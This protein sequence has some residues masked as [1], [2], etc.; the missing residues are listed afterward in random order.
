M[1]FD[2]VNVNV[3]GPVQPTSIYKTKVLKGNQSFASQVTESNTKYVIKHDFDLKGEEVEIPAN[4]VL[5]FDGGS[6]TNGTILFNDTYIV[7]IATKLSDIIDCYIQGSY[8][9]TNSGNFEQFINIHTKTHGQYNRGVAMNVIANGWEEDMPAGITGVT[10]GKQASSYAGRDSVAAYF[11]NAEKAPLIIEGAVF[12]EDKVYVPSNIDLREFKEG[13]YI[14]A[15]DNGYI[16]S[17]DNSHSRWTSI[18]DSVDA[19]NGIIHLKF[20]GFYKVISGGS[21]NAET[22][23]EGSI[24]YIGLITKILALNSQVICRGEEMIPNA[25]VT[26]VCGYELDVN[27]H[28]EGVAGD[29]MDIVN[30]GSVRG[31]YGCTAQG[32]SGK[33]AFTAGFLSRGNVMAFLSR[34]P[35]EEDQTVEYVLRHD[36]IDNGRYTP[37]GYIDKEFDYHKGSDVISIGKG[38]S[39]IIKANG[40]FIKFWG[41][42]SGINIG[43]TEKNITINQYGLVPNSSFNLGAS[44][45]EF[46]NLYLHNYLILG[47]VYIWTNGERVFYRKGAPQEANETKTIAIVK[48]GNERPIGWEVGAM[49]FDTTLGTNGKPIWYIGENKWVD[50]T[51]VIV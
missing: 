11:Q 38:V 47:G 4:C 29:G 16:Y 37:V 42:Q 36:I 28:K 46:N 25:K 20:G 9:F 17:S 19:K 24:L 41:G 2:N 1:S 49:F 30:I 8:T 50:A 14:D 43:Y 34:Q 27:V 12:S 5:E 48:S 22:P 31:Q 35:N 15:F 26:S 21:N 51:G 18:I 3:S 44:S 13:D 40:C 7:T 32:Q 10:S 6:L 39:S 33:A 23:T 45:N